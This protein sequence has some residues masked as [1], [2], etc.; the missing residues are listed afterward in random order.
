MSTQE[1]KMVDVTQ[2]KIKGPLKDSKD[3]KDSN[4]SKES[5]EFI[6]LTSYTATWCN[7]CK[8]IKP[9]VSDILKDH[10]IISVSSITKEEYK[11][12]IYEFVPY[13]TFTKDSVLIDEIQTS[14]E[15]EFTLFFNKNSNELN[16]S[17]GS[18]K[19]LVIDEDF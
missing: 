7:P 5:N 19:D 15:D 13:F 11:K 10:E 12:N 14:K 4:N 8:R 1:I 16:G 17:N 3:S 18:E 9:I 6:I 2:W